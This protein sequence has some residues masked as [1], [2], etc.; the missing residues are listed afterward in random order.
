MSDGAD[1]ACTSKDLFGNFAVGE[2]RAKTSRKYLQM[3]YFLFN[4]D[5]VDQLS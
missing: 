1:L 5:N 3:V 2:L 4:L